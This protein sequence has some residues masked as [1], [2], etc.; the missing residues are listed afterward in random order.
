MIS[1]DNYDRFWTATVDGQRV[2]VYRANYTY[3]AIRLPA[4]E[5]VVEWRYNPWPVKAMWIWFYA[6]LAMFG[7][8]WVLWYRRYSRQAHSED[9]AAV[10]SRQGWRHLL[11]AAQDRP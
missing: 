7:G 5:H 3:K 10:C 9:A 4:G 8:A 6:V 11:I 2:P 1:N